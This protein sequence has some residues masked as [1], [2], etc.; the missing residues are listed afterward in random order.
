MNR[1]EYKDVSG[2]R[3]RWNI[4]LTDGEIELLYKG[5]SPLLIHPDNLIEYWALPAKIEDYNWCSWSGG[6]YKP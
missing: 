1:K 2:S 6:Q 5:L 3:A 4:E